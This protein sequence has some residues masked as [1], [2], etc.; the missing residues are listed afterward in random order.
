MGTV[1]RVTFYRCAGFL[2]L[3]TLINVQRFSEVSI[4]L[5]YSFCSQSLQKANGCE[6]ARVFYSPSAPSMLSSTGSSDGPLVLGIC[7]TTATSGVEI[8]SAA[9]LK[10]PLYSLFE[11]SYMRGSVDD[12]TQML[13]STYHSDQIMRSHIKRTVLRGSQPTEPE[14][15]RCARDT[16]NCGCCL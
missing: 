11:R 13:T 14:S 3:G 12:F 10:S 2:E 16:T 4:E 15:P 9:A 5:L 1:Q 8:H 7:W 6:P